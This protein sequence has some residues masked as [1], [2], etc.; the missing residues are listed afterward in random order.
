MTQC[1]DRHKRKVIDLK[2][3]EKRIRARKKEKE[4][5]RKKDVYDG[6]QIQCG[7]LALW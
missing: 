4:K 2:R 1:D 7:L 3:K 6:C 5:K